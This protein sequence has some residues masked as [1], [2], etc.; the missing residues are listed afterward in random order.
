MTTPLPSTFD[1]REPRRCWPWTLS[2]SGPWTS[3]GAP[4]AVSPF[5]FGVRLGLGVDDT[6][7]GS[8]LFTFHEGIGDD[9]AASSD[10]VT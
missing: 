1:V 2:R 10:V 5:S 9:P 8:C 6:A 3:A 7:E 4:V